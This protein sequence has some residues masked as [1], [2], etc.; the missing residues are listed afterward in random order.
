MYGHK[1]RARIKEQTGN[2]K[3][4]FCFNYALSLDGNL[5]LIKTKSR[6]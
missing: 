4:S 1:L 3:F 5:V 2:I 6:G